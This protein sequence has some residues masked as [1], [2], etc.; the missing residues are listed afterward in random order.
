MF[1]ASKN[2]RSVLLRRL[3]PNDYDDLCYYFQ[4]LQHET[5]RRYGPHGFDKQAVTDLYQ[6]TDLHTGYIAVDYETSRIIA[7]AILKQG[8]LE[9]DSD[10]LQHYG[11]TLNHET[12]CTFAPSVADEWQ[13]QGIGNALFRFILSELKTNGIKRI[14][15]WGGV[16]ADNE[17]AVKFYLKNGFQILGQFEYHG[18]NY[19]MMVTIP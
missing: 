3:L 17:K 12:D 19:D 4:H 6:N 14:I 16:Q 8:Y 2:D 15:L 11:L 13:S 5:T 10:R 7:Y 18:I 9:H 1:I